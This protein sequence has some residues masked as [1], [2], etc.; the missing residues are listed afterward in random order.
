[1]LSYA[2]YFRTSFLNFCCGN[3]ISN[4]CIYI[5]NYIDMTYLICWSD[6]S[7]G[8]PII[9]TDATW[10]H[11]TYTF[12]VNS[13]NLIYFQ[14]NIHQLTNEMNRI[15]VTHLVEQVIPPYLWQ[16]LF[17]KTAHVALRCLAGTPQ[18]AHSRRCPCYWRLGRR[19]TA[20]QPAMHIS[21]E[22]STE[23]RLLILGSIFCVGMIWKIF[24]I[25]LFD[26]YIRMER[27]VEQSH[28]SW[29]NVFEHLRKQTCKL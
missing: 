15:H 17:N 12:L 24:R 19:S 14:Q 28:G 29:E 21:F 4:Y 6:I 26:F 8:N 20:S 2:R 18:V 5:H 11:D 9:L 22:D 1:M 3:C 27:S 23:L 16:F 10:C 25:V 13:P 7:P